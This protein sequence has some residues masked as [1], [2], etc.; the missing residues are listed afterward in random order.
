MTGGT[1]AGARSG[2]SYPELNVILRLVAIG[3]TCLT[4]AVLAALFGAPDDG[5]LLAKLV[6]ACCLLLAVAAI[7][8][9]WLGRAVRTKKP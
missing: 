9:A 2:V 1:G 3:V 6:S 7:A 5:P 8:W 4:A